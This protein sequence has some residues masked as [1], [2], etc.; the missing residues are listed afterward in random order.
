MEINWILM[1]SR[2]QAACE[3]GECAAVDSLS[4]DKREAGT[5]TRAT[6]CSR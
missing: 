2:E 6:E 1:R 4:Q 3:T 5:W